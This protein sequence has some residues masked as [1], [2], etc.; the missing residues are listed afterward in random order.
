MHWNNFGSADESNG[1]KERSQEFIEPG[2]LGELCREPWDELSSPVDKKS[3][4]CACKKVGQVPE[5][6]KTE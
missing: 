1:I 6:D 2:E 4:S 5:R 3:K